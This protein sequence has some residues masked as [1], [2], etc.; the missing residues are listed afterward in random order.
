MIEFQYM[1]GDNGMFG[2]VL[3]HVF[4]YIL[5]SLCL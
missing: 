4:F 3:I 2:N 5:W 1:I